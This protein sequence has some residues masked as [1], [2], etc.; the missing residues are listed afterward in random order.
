MQADCVS[1]SL[2][3]L[4]QIDNPCKTYSMYDTRASLS[5]AHE[6]QWN[7]SQHAR[8]SVWFCLQESNFHLVL[9]VLRYACS[10]LN[11]VLSVTM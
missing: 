10:V 7:W 9:T 6:L 3:Q 11:A 8:Y 5:A 1:L 4:Y 2:C